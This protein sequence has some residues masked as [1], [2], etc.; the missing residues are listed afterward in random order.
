MMMMMMEM[1][2]CNLLT[3]EFLRLNLVGATI[4][5]YQWSSRETDMEEDPNNSLLGRFGRL[6]S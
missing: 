4:P 5:K 1:V 3:L 2:C 6:S